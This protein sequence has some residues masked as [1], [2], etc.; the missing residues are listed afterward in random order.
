M[1]AI[2]R[3]QRALDEIRNGKMVI[4]VDDEDRENE[5][6]LVFAAELVTPEHI[7]FMATHARG[8][9]CLAM[10]DTLI[11]KL[12]LPMMGRDNQASLGTAFSVSIEARHGV[13]TGISARDRATT[14][15]AAIADDA[16]ASDLVSPGHIFPLRARKGGV[17]VRTGQTEG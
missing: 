5:G 3:V 15:R 14:I 17:L 13:S 6:D 11:D 10:D 7:N 1:T 9:I 12:E 16:R 8:L 2:D 4:L